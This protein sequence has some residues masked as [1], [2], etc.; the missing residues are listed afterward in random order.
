DFLRLSEGP[1]LVGKWSLR[2]PELGARPATSADG[3]SRIVAQSGA[4]VRAVHI[5]GGEVTRVLQ[6]DSLI[7]EAPGA[8]VAVQVLARDTAMQPARASLTLEG[9]DYLGRADFAGRILMQP[10]LAGRYRAQL[11]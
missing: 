7:Y 3:L 5:S 1:W 2:M 8:R 10:V 9:T 4:V 6:H 11:T